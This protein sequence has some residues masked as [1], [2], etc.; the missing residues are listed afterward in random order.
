VL[1]ETIQEAFEM[2]SKSFIALI[3]VVCLTFILAVGGCRI[4][5]RSASSEAA[6]SGEVATA[7]P[8]GT[9]VDLS[10]SAAGDEDVDLAVKEEIRQKYQLK[11]GSSV[12]IRGIN[13]GV[14]IETSADT[15]TAE[16]LIVRSAKSAEDLRQYRQVRIEQEDDTLSVRI[17]SD[18]KSLFSA[19]GSIPEG[20]QRVIM[21]LPR[22]VDLEIRGANGNVTVGE[23]QGRMEMSGVNGKIKAARVAGAT[24]ING[25]NGGID[26]AFAPLTGNGISING[27]N[28]NIDLSFEGEVNADLNAWGITGQIHPDLPGI[29]SRNDEESQSR[30]RARIGTGGTQIRIGG[31]N[32]NVNLVK[33]GKAGATAAKAAAK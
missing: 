25:C 24:Q 6:K 23:I 9:P 7:Q 32:G 17:E 22:K 27:I 20:R 18:R 16:V 3:A 13:G 19:I 5:R 2:K 29:E 28:G 1:I 15:D 11:P 21:K 31:I 26:V 10:I 8:S 33:A 14:K 30:L 4:G 12:E